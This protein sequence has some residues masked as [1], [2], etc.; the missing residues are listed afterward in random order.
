MRT[1][2]IQIWR[3]WGQPFHLRF[4]EA[5]DIFPWVA[6]LAEI[7][8][9]QGPLYKVIPLKLSKKVAPKAPLEAS[10]GRKYDFPL[11]HV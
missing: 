3:W 8:I 7:I 4:A 11:R 1:T 9:I 5:I 2:D 6:S 10:S